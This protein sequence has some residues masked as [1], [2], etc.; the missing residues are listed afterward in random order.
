[1]VAV[2]PF[3]ARSGAAAVVTAAVAGD[4]GWRDVQD[5]S[6]CDIAGLGDASGLLGS[7]ALGL[8]A[9]VVQTTCAP[10]WTNSV[11]AAAWSG[12]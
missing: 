11:F 12:V 7:P 4:A 3:I 8:L 10:I 9:A 2:G 5:T 1:V 6:G